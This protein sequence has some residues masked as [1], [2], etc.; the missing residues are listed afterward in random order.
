M[1]KLRE[2]LGGISQEELAR[3]ISASGQTVSRWERGQ[4]AQ[5]SIPQIKALEEILESLNLKFRD[6]SDD[7]S[8]NPEPAQP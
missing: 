8:V 7:L 1:K 3:R 6:L 4:N 5:L 2:L